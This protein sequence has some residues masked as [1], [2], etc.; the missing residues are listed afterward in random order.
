MKLLDFAKSLI[1]QPV[2][3]G[4]LIKMF[5]VQILTPSII[6]IIS[7]KVGLR[8]NYWLK[9]NQLEGVLLRCL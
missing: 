9:L 4:F 2:S 7:S 3:H 8:S 5:I 1:T 6:E